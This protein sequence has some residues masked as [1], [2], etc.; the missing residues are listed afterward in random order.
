VGFALGEDS[1]TGQVTVMIQQQMQLH[2]ALGAAKLCPIVEFQA[3][4]NDQTDQLVLESVNRG[5]TGRFLS[6]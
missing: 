6:I 4:I 1:E 3:E 5:Q 2:R